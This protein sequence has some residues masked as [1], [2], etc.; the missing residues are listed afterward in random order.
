M[1]TEFANYLSGET[2]LPPSLVVDKAATN[3]AMHK[4]R[5]QRSIASENDTKLYKQIVQMQNT[6]K[7]KSRRKTAL[8]VYRALIGNVIICTGTWS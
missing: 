2:Q 7:E 1:E 4:R 6:E 3:A 5:R 8:N